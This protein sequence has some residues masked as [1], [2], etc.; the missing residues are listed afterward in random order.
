MRLHKKDADTHHTKRKSVGT[1]G[2]APVGHCRTAEQRRA[3]WGHHSDLSSQPLARRTAMLP[4]IS[5]T[6]STRTLSGNFYPLSATCA[7]NVLYCIPNLACNQSADSP[8]ALRISIS[9]TRATLVGESH[10]LSNMHLIEL[11]SQNEALGGVHVMF[12]SSH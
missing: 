12:I 5:Q 7:Q 4:S 10:P 6:L 9:R 11:R 8:D 1:I 2:I 3:Y